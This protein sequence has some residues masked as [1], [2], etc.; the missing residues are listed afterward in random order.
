MAN[1]F[2]AFILWKKYFMATKEL[3]ILT[4]LNT[5]Q[6]LTLKKEP[7]AVTAVWQKWRF[8]SS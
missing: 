8:G 2:A 3:A 4:T 6:T 7:L 5:R 1:T